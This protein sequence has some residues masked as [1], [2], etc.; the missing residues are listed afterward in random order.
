MWGSLCG[1][2]IGEVRDKVQELISSGVDVYAHAV[3]EEEKAGL[4]T[5]GQAVMDM[6]QSARYKESAMKAFNRRVVVPRSPMLCK[7][8]VFLF[9][10]LVNH[11]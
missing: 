6:D 5:A 11:A 10:S 2:I 8:S 4:D 1:S 3:T 7:D 9:F